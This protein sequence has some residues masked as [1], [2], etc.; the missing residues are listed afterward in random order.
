MAAIS[1]A[2]G[3]ERRS[4]TTGY[5]LKKGFF[6]NETPNLPQQIVI[7][8]EANTANQASISTT[9]KLIT[10]AADA[11]AIFGYGSP[12]HQIMRILRPV[13]GDGVG[14]IPTIVMPQLEAGG[15]TAT[16]NVWTITGPATASVTHY[17]RIAGREALE[18]KAYAVNIVIGDTAS[19]IAQKYADAVNSVL[20]SPVLAT[21]AGAVVTYTT[22]W[23]GAS[24]A[25]LK[26]S[27]DTV[28]VPAGLT[29]ALVATPGTGAADISAALLQFEDNWYTTVIN[30]YGA[31]V[32]AALELFNGVP[33]DTAPTGRYEGRVFKPFMAFFGTTL[34]VINDITAITNAGARVNQVTNV[35]APAPGSEGFPWEAAAN[36]V[37]L[38]TRTVQD[39]PSSDVLYQYY[40]DM[41]VPFSEGIGPMADYNNRDLLLKAGSST[42]TLKNNQ[43]LVIDLV[44]T[45][46]PIG[47]DPLQYN[48]ARNLNLD[49]NIA[50]G[51]RL[52]EDRVLV[53]KVIIPD[54][55]VTSVDNAIKPKEWKAN[56][57]DYLDD[58][59]SDALINDPQFSKDGLQVEID[60]DNPNRFNTSF[61]YRRTGTVRISSTTAQ[62]GF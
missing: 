30:S 6:N 8:A 18:G 51:Y 13:S 43:Y 17:I 21:A 2:V 42:V 39:N 22:K 7:L 14:G 3:S 47:E 26:T 1:S 32:F 57:Y 12:I 29:Y 45:Y 28:G 52:M 20:G 41:P 31:T 5:A 49:W 25:E 37:R 4:A 10:S 40:P 59:A 61:P 48:Y 23:K 54:D 15:A 56:V 9:K 58:K 50:Y 62:A 36:M 46:H 38:F 24:S 11:G 33:N 34:S 35:H 27:I 19:A 53:G 55:Q 44:T 16:T 60:E